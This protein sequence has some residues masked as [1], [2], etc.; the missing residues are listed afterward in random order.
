MKSE[1]V[2]VNIVKQWKLAALGLTIGIVLNVGGWV[3][4]AQLVGR[5]APHLTETEML[6]T[7]GLG[8]IAIYCLAGAAALLVVSLVEYAR[9]GP[10][11]IVLSDTP[12]VPNRDN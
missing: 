3:A 5:V 7:T 6:S 10:I 8:V 2:V 11:D 1:R 9:V 12:T 4:W